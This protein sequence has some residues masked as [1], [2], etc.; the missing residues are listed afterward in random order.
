MSVCAQG[1]ALLKWES[2]VLHKLQDSDYV[3]RWIAFG[4]FAAQYNYVRA[5]TVS[6]SH[7]EP[8]AGSLSVS[9]HL[10]CYLTPSEA[11]LMGL[12]RC[13]TPCL[14]LSHT[15]SDRSDSWMQVVMSLLQYNLSEHRK[16]QFGATTTDTARHW[17]TQDGDTGRRSETQ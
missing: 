6:H 10:T 11:S 5:L 1:W 13:L 9:Y 14:I 3:C 12:T 4:N 8:G 15:L 16:Q 7:T 17:E 2:E